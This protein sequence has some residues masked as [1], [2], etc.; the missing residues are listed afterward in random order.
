MAKKK[1]VKLNTKKYNITISGDNL[2]GLKLINS[3]KELEKK[4]DKLE[5]LQQNTDNKLKQTKEKLN[6][7]NYEL[8]DLRR[9]VKT[10]KDNEKLMK[11]AVNKYNK[12]REQV[13]YNYQ[14]TPLA[15]KA[16]YITYCMTDLQLASKRLE[17]LLKDVPEVIKK[18]EAKEK[19]KND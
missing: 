15:K 7:A 9:F 8:K 14:Y 4:Y 3:Y 13:K 19:K 12:L 11:S 1:Q 18:I 5:K 16:Q 10:Y 2:N 17:K 6:L